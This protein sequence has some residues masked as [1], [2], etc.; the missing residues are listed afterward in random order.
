MS[1]IQRT[2]NVPASGAPVSKEAL[3]NLNRREFLKLSAMLGATAAIPSKLA[4]VTSERSIIM[5]PLASRSGTPGRTLFTQL[6][7]EET[8]IVTENNY[9]DP[10]ATRGTVTDPRVW[11]DRFREFEVGAVGTGIAI[12]DYDNDGRPDIFVVSKTESCRLFRNLGNY[13]FEDVTEKAGVG[14]RGD[15]AR[16]WK[17]GATFV[18]VN[19][20][21]LLDIYVCRFN[22]PNLLYINQGDGTFREMAKDFGLAIQ[23]SSVMAAF[24][25]FDRD[26]WLDVFVLTNLLNSEV[27][28]KGQPSYLLRNNRNGTFTDITSAAG[29]SGPCRGHSAIWWDYDNDGWPDLYVGNDFDVPDRLYR[30]NRDGTFTNV[31]DQVLPHMPY[32]SMGSDLG[33]IN[34]DGLIDFLA[35]DMSPT[36]HEKDQRTVA[37]SR[38]LA[39]D[40]P[41]GSNGAPQYFRNCLYINTGTGR[42]LEAACMAGL[43]NTDWTWSAR[44]E[45]LDNDGR[46]DLFITNGMHREV[47]NVDVIQRLLRADSPTEAAKIELHSP[48]LIERHLAFRNLG[49][50]K[51]VETGEQWG[52]DKKGVSFGTAFGDFG[53]NGN[54]DI[55]YS[56]YRE[57]VTFLRN[58]CHEHHRVVVELRGVHSNRFGVGSVVRIRTKTGI[59]VRQL[60][61]ARGLVSSS[62]PILHFGLGN[63]LAI[64]ELSV[65]WPSGIEQVFTNLPVDYRFTIMEAEEQPRKDQQ[66]ST[67][68]FCDATDDSGLSFQFHEAPID[69]QSQQALLPFRQNRRG[70]ALAVGKLS[71][72]G[73]DAIVM[74]GTSSEPAQVILGPHQRSI[75]SQAASAA[76]DDGPALVFDA[77]CDG[78]NDLILTRGGTRSPAGS[79]DYQPLLLLNDGSGLLNPTKGNWLPPLPISAGAVAAA[80]FNRDGRLE[81]FIGGKV[82]PGQYPTSPTSALLC[83]NGSSYEDVSTTLAPGL[84]EV[85]MVTSAL[86]SDVDGDGWVDLLLT[87]EWGKVRYFHN[88]HGRSLDDWTERAGFATAGNG[89]WTSI[90]AADFNR[91]GKPEY[92][93][94]NVGLNT[95]YRA[96]PDQPAVLYYG[97]FNGDGTPQILEAY[98]EDGHLYP[99]RTFRE[100]SAVFPHL[101][102]KFSSNNAFARASLSEIF[103]PDLLNSAQRFTATEFCSGVFLRR[104]DNRFD[105]SPLPRMA[106]IAPIQGLVAGDFDG[107]GFAD[108]VAV[109]NSY[110]PAPYVGRFDG[111]LGVFLKGDGKGQFEA[112]SALAS[113][114]VVPGDAKSLVV[115]DMNDDGWP[116]L[117]VSRNDDRC[118]AL[119]NGRPGSGR[120]SLKV[121]LHGPH[122]NP[123]SVGALVEAQ[124]DDGAVLGQEV[125][126]GSG[127][128]SQSTAAL[129][130]GWRDPNPLRSLKVRWPSGASS[131]HTV[132]MPATTFHIRDPGF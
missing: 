72:T 106:Q 85:G 118:I 50:L 48:R 125:H 115:F 37:N 79:P 114:I 88:N 97:D 105:F 81:V 129:F 15:D 78:R 102:G 68:L 7:A 4:E 11:A 127:H 59:Q 70:P 46:L 109:Q 108:I 45:D 47:H 111:G 18:D 83:F 96:S 132:K 101:R 74:S 21:G 86:W 100:L 90:A 51:F 40:P 91:D 57:G 89:W 31:I 32:S 60:V 87:V 39:V 55:V 92:V 112:I 16:I 62:E 58:D 52:L 126:A 93:V 128:Q 38:A 54:L 6:S 76:V 110:A 77:D 27:N 23:D 124:Y 99:W 67:A 1:S 113:G 49:D 75:I 120:N 41:E 63:D 95:P 42:C 44:W 13:R 17:Q 53:G 22:A 119:R 104:G 9:A 3:S 131:T 20:D 28:P 26:G 117:L 66:G 107:D 71:N 116:D 14:D 103:S 8:G 122:G 30:N 64:Q 56:N 34:N 24:C 80:D 84:R 69:E 36:N 25:D 130:F 121:I 35:T 33:D 94:G 12:G 10:V 2:N 29:I 5:R 43:A 65:S 73:N 19:N 98:Y 82:L 123:D 61:L